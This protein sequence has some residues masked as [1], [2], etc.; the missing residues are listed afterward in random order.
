VKEKKR[1]FAL[2]WIDIFNWALYFKLAFKIK[3]A[4]QKPLHFTLTY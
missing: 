1:T 2:N 4:R 3:V